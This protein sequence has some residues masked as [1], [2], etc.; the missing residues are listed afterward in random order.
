M[1]LDPSLDPH[2]IIVG[3][4]L[5]DH[6]NQCLMGYF[7]QVAD[8]LKRLVASFHFSY[9]PPCEVD[10]EVRSLAT[11]ISDCYNQGKLL[12]LHLTDKSKISLKLDL[13]EEDFIVYTA[14]FNSSKVYEVARCFPIN[15][16]PFVGL[17][18]C[19]T[20]NYNDAQLIDKIV[21]IDDLL[22]T[23]VHLNRLK[24]TL[25]ERRSNYVIRETERNVLTDQDVAYEEA[26]LEMKRLEEEEIQKMANIE[27]M[28]RRKQLIIDECERRFHKLPSEPSSNDPNSITLKISLP[29]SE[30]KIRRFMK[31]DP[32][33][34]LYDYV[35]FDGAPNPPKIKFGFPPQKVK[36]LERTFEEYQFMKK[37]SVF[38]VF[39]VDSSSE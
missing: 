13:N 39:R 37:D 14:P 10:T 5:V 29:N 3:V 30:P 18:Y 21:D 23:G 1:L 27:E 31:T 34:F 36:N 7:F 6:V 33:Q 28:K 9:S 22:R 12:V 16:L 17:F 25:Y 11:A 38:V 20:S 4:Y 2:Y 26:L 19:P 24:N 15:G 32:L 8:C 35:A